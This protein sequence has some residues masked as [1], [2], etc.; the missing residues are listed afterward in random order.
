MLLR[1][2]CVLKEERDATIRM[3]HAG[4]AR[5]TGA[6]ISDAAPPGRQRRVANWRTT[7]GDAE[8]RPQHAVVMQSPSR[9]SIRDRLRFRMWTAGDGPW[10][11]LRL[12]ARLETIVTME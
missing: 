9:Q 3:R 2:D 7:N 11:G 10:R 5:A 8:R 12:C 6:S 1:D 4:S